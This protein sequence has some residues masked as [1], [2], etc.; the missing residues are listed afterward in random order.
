MRE[1]KNHKKTGTLTF[2][3]DSATNDNKMY[4]QVLIKLH[5]TV[6]HLVAI[7]VPTNVGSMVEN[8]L[9]LHALNVPALDQSANRTGNN[10]L[11]MVLMKPMELTVVFHQNH[12][13]HSV[14][15][16]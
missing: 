1:Q 8:L 6:Q 9:Y 13:I 16:C 2:S 11:M 14:N 15:Y 4:K 12:V 10:I 3:T 5:L 7:Y